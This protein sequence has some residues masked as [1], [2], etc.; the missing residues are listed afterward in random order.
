MPPGAAPVPV[1]P[2]LLRA[3][4]PCPRQRGLITVG[5]AGHLSVLTDTS[6][7]V[8]R[9]PRF[10]TDFAVFVIGRGLLF[11]VFC[12]TMGEVSSDTRTIWHSAPLVGGCC[13]GSR[14]R[15]TGGLF[16]IPGP[17]KGIQGRG[18]RAQIR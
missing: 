1:P 2:S 11:V 3:R 5:G 17:Q 7:F 10:L 18:Y 13:I 4:P 12:G 6:Q 15:Y 16:C 9:S 8:K 14:V